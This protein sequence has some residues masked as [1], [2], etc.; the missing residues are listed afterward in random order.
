MRGIQFVQ[1]EIGGL[2]TAIPHHHDG[3]LVPTGSSGSSHPAPLA[4]GPG[5]LPLP[6]ERFEKEGLI[7]LDNPRF[8]RGTVANS[9]MAW[10][11]SFHHR[12]DGTLKS[13]RL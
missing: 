9:S 2:T 1:S 7:G 10:A 12:K 13:E 4:C 3:N 8:M 11:F 6:L 5:Q